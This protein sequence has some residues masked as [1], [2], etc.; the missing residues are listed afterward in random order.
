MSI[1]VVGSIGYD[2][3]ET[4][5][6]RIADALG[7]SASFFSVAARFFAPVS[8]VAVVGEDFKS[9][10]VKF[11][12]DRNVDIRGL[13]HEKG[14]TFRWH[15]RYHEDMNQR[16]TLHLA[17]NVFADFSPDLLPDQRRAD[18][19]FLANISPQLQSRVLS[20]MTNPKVV[21]A[22]TMDHWIN[23][24]R[25]ALIKMLAKVDILT[26][27]D[28]EAKLLAQEHNL[29]KAGR[30]ILK[31]G[32]KTVLV[33]RGEYG[34]LLF[35]PESM[36]AVPAYPLEEVIDPT[37]AGDTFAGGFMGFIA[38]SGK[39]SEP[40]LRKAVVYGSVMGSFVVERFSLDRLSDL[41]WETIDARYRAFV[42]LTDSQHTKWNS[43]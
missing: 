2:T 28:Q 26:L 34:V 22:D 4:Q 6:G 29:V 10:D 16:D 32:P 24:E 39:V 37:G 41:S 11:F 9:D 12:T 23:T 33:K 3:V 31:M 42:E 15:G 43:Q 38:R 17:L 27:N 8:M 20:Q 14:E 18:Y 13:V 5:H 19:L 25:A 30:A 1:V 40:V 7:G 36:F 35:S 21:A